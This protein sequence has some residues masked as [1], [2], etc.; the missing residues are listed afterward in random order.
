MHLRVG[1][2]E[3]EEKRKIRV[4]VWR[5]VTEMRMG[6]WHLRTYLGCRAIQLLQIRDAKIVSKKRWHKYDFEKAISRKEGGKI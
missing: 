4:A 3:K 1:K 2:V 5:Q 6:M